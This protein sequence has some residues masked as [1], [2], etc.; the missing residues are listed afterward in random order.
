MVKLDLSK[1]H[2][3]IVDFSAL[4]SQLNFHFSYQLT[5]ELFTD[6]RLLSLHIM[7]RHI[8]YRYCMFFV[9]F[10]GHAGNKIDKVWQQI[11]Q[12]KVVGIG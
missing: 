7:W 2:K 4:A 5:T 6:S 9:F 10:V 11:S 8:I 1:K 3:I 12:R